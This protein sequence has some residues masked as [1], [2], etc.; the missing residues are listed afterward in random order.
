M[1]RADYPAAVAAVLEDHYPV[2][3]L[4]YRGEYYCPTCT[5]QAHDNQPYPCAV[6]DLM[7][8]HLPQRMLTASAR[9]REQQQ[10]QEKQD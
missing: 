1:P 7:A 6:I 8:P 4:G 2:P 5:R 9:W 10:R 3:E